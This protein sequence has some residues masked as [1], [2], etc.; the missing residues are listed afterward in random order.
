MTGRR[1]ERK[2]VRL[3]DDHGWRYV[4]SPSSGSGRTDDQP[5]LVVG[6]APLGV[7]PLGIEAKTTAKD[8]YTIAE[9]EAD[10][11]RRWCEGFGAAPVIAMYWK[12]PAGGNVSYGG[13]WFLGLSEVRRS[14]SK[15]SGGGHHL[16][17]RRE[18]RHLWAGIGDLDEGRL[19]AGPVARQEARRPGPGER[20]PDGAETET[21]DEP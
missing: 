9:A 6:K 7:P 17:P 8:A 12:G 20:G 13:W 14:P 2:L 3:F 11:L 16:R 1:Y 15:N 21:E 10:Q 4:K 5:D 18:D 19:M